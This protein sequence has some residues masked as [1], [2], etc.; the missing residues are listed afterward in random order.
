[1][2]L[3]VQSQKEGEEGRNFADNGAWLQK[4]QGGLVAQGH[5]SSSTKP[6]EPSKPPLG[7]GGQTCTPGQAP[8]GKKVLWA[9]AAPCRIKQ[10]SQENY[11]PN[12]L[13]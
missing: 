1:M 6:P 5:Q 3:V 4:S 9:P 2:G 11:V 10:S 7:Q 13:E 8:V 12:S